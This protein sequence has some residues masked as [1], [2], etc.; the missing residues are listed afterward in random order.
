VPAAVA[1]VV[2]IFKTDEPDPATE[3]GVKVAV[4]PAGNP[5]IV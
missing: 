5:L 2:E 4:A 1:L 3:D